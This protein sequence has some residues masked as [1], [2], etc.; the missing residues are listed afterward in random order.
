M[1]GSYHRAPLR[2]ARFSDIVLYFTRVFA[3]QQR[4]IFGITEQSFLI[5]KTKQKMGWRFFFQ[6]DAL[7][8]LSLA[9]AGLR[10][11]HPGLR[12][13]SRPTPR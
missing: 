10:A 11:P 7:R 9:Y 6:C 8:A 4:Q 12:G 13:P 2:A 3:I 5:I 1:G